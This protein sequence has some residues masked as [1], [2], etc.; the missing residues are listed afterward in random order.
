[1]EQLGALAALRIIKLRDYGADLLQLIEEWPSIVG[2]R[3]AQHSRPT[4]LAHNN[5]E[6]SV[7]CN[8]I[9]MDLHHSNLA[10]TIS[11]R[12]GHNVRVT[13]KKGFTRS[14]GIRQ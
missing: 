9:V 1:V 2:E 12:L 10:G 13:L 8:S 5:L 14:K 4:R 3:L 11:A 7:Y 6:V